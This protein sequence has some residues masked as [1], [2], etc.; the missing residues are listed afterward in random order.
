MD[1]PYEDHDF[2]KND[3][4][5][6]FVYSPSPSKAICWYEGEEEPRESVIQ[7][8]RDLKYWLDDIETRQS[9]SGLAVIL[10]ARHKQ[11]DNPANLQYVP[12]SREGFQMMAES[13]PLHGDTA[14]HINRTD[15]PYFTDINLTHR[16]DAVYHICRTPGTT[17]G[18]LAVSSVFCPKTGFTRGVVFGCSEEVTRA[19]DG[20]IYNSERAWAHP[21]LLVGIL[22]ELERI[23][24]FDLVKERVHELLL[25]VRA[26]NKA[27]TISSTSELAQDNYSVNRWI[28][29]SQLMTIL[30]AWKVQLNKMD[31]HIT[32]LENALFSDAQGPAQDGSAGT[33]F[34][35]SSSSTLSSTWK[36]AAKE[37]GRRIQK[38]LREILS[39]Y[40][41]KIRECVMVLDG[42]AL[43]A[44]LSWNQIGYQDTQANLKIASDTRR[45]SNQM[46][47]IAFLTMIF[48]PATFLA[49]LFSMTFFNWDASEGEHVVSPLL[50]I[51]FALAVG[52]TLIVVGCWYLFTRRR[53]LPPDDEENGLGA[54]PQQA[55]TGESLRR[56]TTDTGLPSSPNYASK[57]PSARLTTV[58]SLAPRQVID[59]EKRTPSVRGFYPQ[60][61]LTSRTGSTLKK[62]AELHKTR[63]NRRELAPTFYSTD[64]R[65]TT[66]IPS[67]QAPCSPFMTRIGGALQPPNLK[68]I[69]RNYLNRAIRGWGEITDK[70]PAGQGISSSERGRKT[71]ESPGFKDE[72]MSDSIP[73]RPQWDSKRWKPEG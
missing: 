37:T 24:H 51:Y 10:A 9:S 35:G 42:M 5:E 47:S 60:K 71:G 50:W 69:N 41:G 39:E 17:P 11:G 45:D 28:L 16:G 46:R 56:V 30:E 14:R 19:F 23:R 57:K 62:P 64:S 32:D 55:W 67:P 44:Q 33:S 1:W 61:I 6:V 26:M 20:R 59:S 70:A 8:D 68:L 21:M 48:L 4:D 36:V 38:R 18:D 29:V 22:V 40:D 54:E 15:V 58:R 66:L 73:D 53:K 27:E 12:F 3:L 13:L 65:A 43:A 49:S 34:G 25:Q 7:T 52:I 63:A 72:A 31:S 2:D